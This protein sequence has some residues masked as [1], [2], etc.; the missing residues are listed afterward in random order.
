MNSCRNTNPADGQADFNTRQDPSDASI[1]TNS[2]YLSVTISY[3]S[4]LSVSLPCGSY[5]QPAPREGDPGS[6]PKTKT[7]KH[8]NTKTP[9]R[10]TPNAK[11]QNKGKNIG[12]FVLHPTRCMLSRVAK[13]NETIEGH[14][15]GNA[16]LD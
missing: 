11:R 10:Q 2:H 8:Q 6:R 1:S 9:E 16:N 13:T 12:N 4:G 7:P 5:S 14:L 15:K 3:E